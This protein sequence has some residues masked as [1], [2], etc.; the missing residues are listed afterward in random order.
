MM[1]GQVRLRTKRKLGRSCGKL[2]LMAAILFTSSACTGISETPSLEEYFSYE[3]CWEFKSDAGGGKRSIAAY[4]VLY[5]LGSVGIVPDFVSTRCKLSSSS[6][7]SQ[8]R[9][10]VDFLP[11]QEGEDDLLDGFQLGSNRVMPTPS[12]SAAF[13]VYKITARSIYSVKRPGGLLTLSCLEIDEFETVDV[14][15]KK[16]VADH[17][18]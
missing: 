4:V 7:M 9:F 8:R 11:C 10:L 17:Q 14:S 6:E 12:M 5:D 3:D 2:T 18:W 13:G 1:R 15:P 16:F